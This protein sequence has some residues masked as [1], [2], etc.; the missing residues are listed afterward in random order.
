MF[1]SLVLHVNCANGSCRDG[2]V[3]AGL[4][5]S[6]KDRKQNWLRK[7][8]QTL[9][10]ISLAMSTAAIHEIRAVSESQKQ[11]ALLQLC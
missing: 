5:E 3:L 7:E 6:E 2:C 9:L 8:K 4:G 11:M 10:C 1:L